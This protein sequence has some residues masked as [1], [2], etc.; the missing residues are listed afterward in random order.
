MSNLIIPDDLRLV[1]A[2]QASPAIVERTSATLYPVGDNTVT[3]GSGSIQSGRIEFKIPVSSYKS[4]DMSTMFIHFNFKI[5]LTGVTKTANRQTRVMVHDSIESI[6]KTV[7]VDL[8][9]GGY[10]LEYIDHYNAL[11][12]ALN[13]FVSSD[14]IRGFA[15]PCMRAGVHSHIRN[16]IYHTQNYAGTTLGETTNQFSVPLRLAGISSPDFVMP[17]S[18]F[19]SGGFINIYID[20]EAPVACILAGQETDIAFPALAAGATQPITG[21]QLTALTGTAVSYEL[22]NI[23]MT[24]DAITYSSSYENM[25]ASALASSSLV[26]PIKSFDVQPRILAANQTY[27]SENLSFNYSSV[28][29]VFAWFVRSSEQN[30]HL[31]AGKDRLVFPP[32]L[33]TFQFRVNGFPVPAA[34]P[35][36][37][38]NGATEAYC[39]L[40][41]ALG[42]LHTCES[43]GGLNYD[44]PV[45]NYTTQRAVAGLTSTYASLGGYLGSDTFY[46]K[47]RAATYGFPVDMTDAGTETTGP[48]GYYQA[49]GILE[50][51]VVT[52]VDVADETNS[53]LPYKREM[54]PSHFVI[55]VNLKKLLKSAPGEISGESLSTN[56][57]QIAYQV[58]F[59]AND[60][61]SYIMY[62]AVLHDRFIELSNQVVRVNM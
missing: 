40:L 34:R 52:T 42:I 26:Y 35:I 37:C 30:T 53:L 11:E 58:E 29:A 17:S 21:G 43:Y 44:P 7:T 62:V 56:S 28:N 18:L 6:F 13:N 54:S 32:N 12:S 22:S 47:N 31:Y 51:T 55:G 1:Q 33:K 45:V 16:R 10:R 27:F 48:V 4:W 49:G 24:L 50:P 19:G 23:R 61:V 39:H 5:L 38:T 14:Y 3:S 2:Q 41:E 60:P 59:S 20:L 9:G 25:L 15:A 8:A 57:G 36:D 46:G